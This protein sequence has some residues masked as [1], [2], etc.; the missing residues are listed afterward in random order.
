MK[1]LLASPNDLV[2]A[3]ENDA[4]V[5]QLSKVFEELNKNNIKCRLRESGS[6]IPNMLTIYV[7]KI[8]E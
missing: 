1:F 6:G 4:E 8:N 2:L 5:C 7:E 3:T